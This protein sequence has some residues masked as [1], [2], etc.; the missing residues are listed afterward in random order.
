MIL[1]QLFDYGR[2]GMGNVKIGPSEGLGMTSRAQVLADH[3]KAEE[4]AGPRTA[5]Y[6][7]QSQLPAMEGVRGTSYKTGKERLGDG[8]PASDSAKQTQFPGL[9]S[10]EPTT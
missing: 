9:V 7:K 10:G 3:R 4:S 5:D 6:A 8:E 2:N 1:T